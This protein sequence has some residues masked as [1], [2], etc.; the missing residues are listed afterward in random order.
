MTRDDSCAG[1]ILRAAVGL[2][3]LLLLQGCSFAGLESA[4]GVAGSTRG[5]MRVRGVLAAE[6]RLRPEACISGDRGNF[7]GVDLIAPPLVLRVAAEPIDGLALALIDA[8]SGERRAIFR[9]SDCKTLRGDVQRTGWRIN[10]VAD[11]SGFV[12]VD[13]R[14]P[15]GVEM[16]GSIAFE[17]CH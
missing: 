1:A 3:L 17:H 5:E 2:G 9:R 11:V 13:C 15:S 4:V 14:L 12:E 16:E 10:E 7:R 8:E 6:L